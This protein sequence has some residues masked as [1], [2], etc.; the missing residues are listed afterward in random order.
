MSIVRPK[1]YGC[2]S[3]LTPERTIH[4][5]KYTPTLP[6]DYREIARISFEDAPTSFLSDLKATCPGIAFTILGCLRVP[7]AL[8]QAALTL[9][10]F[11]AAI[12]PYLTLHE[13]V[14]G[15]I[16]KAATGRNVTIRFTKTG[17]NCS[18]PEGYVSHPTAVAC[19][20][21]PLVVFSIAFG[22]WGIAALLLKH[23]T[24]L[25]AGLLLTFHL[26]GCR[27]DVHLLRQLRKYGP[28]NT[29]IRDNGAEQWIF[30]K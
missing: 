15:L 20:A 14:H 7:P 2:R 18:L 30:Q 19:T 6:K 22:A 17:A 3:V 11:A 4:M 8:C 10:L 9:L 13:L 12:Y 26:L 1:I 23:G 16:Y 21:G 29:L 24:A 25:L 5:L 27:S 28:A